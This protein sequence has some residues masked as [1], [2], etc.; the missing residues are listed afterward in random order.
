[1]KL[2]KTLIVTCCTFAL[3]TGVAVRA[4]DEKKPC[5]LATAE[6]QKGCEHAC[7][8]KAGEEGKI[9]KKCHKEEK[10]EEAK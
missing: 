2:I 1:M 5:C 9:C 3:L 4:D 7:C 8:K 6:G 10:K